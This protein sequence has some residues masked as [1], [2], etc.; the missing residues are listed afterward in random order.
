MNIK[1]Q[2]I[3]AVCTI[4]LFFEGLAGTFAQTVV[5]Q[6]EMQK[7]YEEVKT[8]YKY[9]LVVTPPSPDKM[10]D[11]PSV[12]RKGEKWYMYYIIFDGRGYETWMAESDDLLHWETKGKVLSFSE[13]T[14]WD[15]NQ[16]A[17]YLALIDNKWGGNYKLRKY[18]SRYWM[19]YLGGN[20]AGYESGTLAVGMAYT[21]KNPTTA[22][23]WQ[24]VEQPVLSP[25]DRDASWWDNGK[26]YKSTVLRDIR[27]QTG[28]KFVMFYNAKGNAERIGMAVSNDMINWK[29][30]GKEPLLDHKRGIT[31]DA[32]IQRLGNLWV[33]FYFGFSW[34]KETSNKAWDTFACSYDLVN[35]TDW[36]GEPLIEPSEAYDALYAHKPCVVKHK[37]IVYH[38]YCAVSKDNNRGIAVA[39]S[40]EIGK[41]TL[42]FE[43][44]VKEN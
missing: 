41:S 1:S 38:F 24:R 8:P 21:K 9:G 22:E 3:K 40:K 4:L 11:S 13:S 30:Y 36:Q 25:T 15:S 10:V 31:G 27:K 23:E 7:V 29:R 43:T 17:G 32:Y 39:T 26:I 2:I 35:W 5:T 34:N 42:H 33:M 28:H 18:D 6:E 19:S 44:T 16:K 12:F 37:G 20:S 14:D